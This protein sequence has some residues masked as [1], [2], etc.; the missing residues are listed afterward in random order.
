MFLTSF[1]EE[2]L[3]ALKRMFA[4][5]DFSNNEIPD[6]IAGT[7]IRNSLFVALLLSILLIFI[8]MRVKKANINKVPSKIVILAEMLVTWINTMCQET[9]G[10][11]YWKKYAPFI[12]TLAVFIFLSNILGIFG[13]ISPT[14]N[15][16][17]TLT[18]GLITAFVLQFTCIKT[19]GIKGFVK[20]LLDPIPI[21]LPLNIISEIVTPIS[22]GMRLFGNI[23]SGAVL[24]NI[25]HFVT[26]DLINELM[27]LLNLNLLA[28]FLGYGVTIVIGVFVHAIFDLFFGAIQTYVFVLLSTTF[29]AGKLPED[30][31]IIEK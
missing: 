24:L 17:V 3:I 13:F 5:P 27:V 18:L 15:V 21:M 20:G 22:L 28:P 1:G 12:L 4:I 2:L 6:F 16:Y 19:Q 31:I 8:G 26:N 10:K 7:S 30:E 29:I 14:G 25:V 23:F 11:K 9:L